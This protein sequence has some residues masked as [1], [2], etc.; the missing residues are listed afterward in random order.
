MSTNTTNLQLTKQA[1][2]EYYSIDVVN[3]NLDKIDAGCVNVT[4]SQTISG[5]KTFS[6]KVI[7]S[8]QKTLHF[9][10]STNR[11]I[12]INTQS[13]T[14]RTTNPSSKIDF[15]IPAINVPKISYTERSKQYEESP[16]IVEFSFTPMRSLMSMMVFI[17]A[18]YEM[19]TPFGTP[20]LPE[21]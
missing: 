5:Q 4:G 15:D 13:Y 2:S 3:A 14:D 8:N 16:R 12:N 10:E 18:A 19:S 9:S 21:V 17:I 6:E 11:A 1:G 7:I 20:V